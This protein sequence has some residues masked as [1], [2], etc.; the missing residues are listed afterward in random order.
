[1]LEHKESLEHTSSRRL[2][3]NMEMVGRR[4]R[5]YFM[6]FIVGRQLPNILDTILQ[7]QLFQR[8]SEA[9]FRTDV[10]LPVAV[11]SA[12]AEFRETSYSY[13]P[14]N[15][16]VG[17]NVVKFRYLLSPDCFL[18]EADRLSACYFDCE[19]LFRV[20]AQDQTVEYE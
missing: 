4:I 16:L 15:E 2:D 12:I 18:E 6:E 1:M 13:L 8:I 3:N 11:V 10:H 5:Q 20:V 7:L 9:G 14:D 17:S 19:E